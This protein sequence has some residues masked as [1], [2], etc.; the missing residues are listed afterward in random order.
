VTRTRRLGALLIA[1]PLAAGFT[2]FANPTA[3]HAVSGRLPSGNITAP[4]DGAV[5]TSG[6]QVTA[7]ATFR[8]MLLGVRLR[9]KTPDG[10][11]QLL[12]SGSMKGE[13]SGTFNIRRNGRY[14]VR[15]VGTT[16][17][18]YDTSTIVVKV[19]PATPSGLSAKVSGGTL[20]VTWNLGLEDD[21]TGYTVQAGGVGSKSGSPQSL[22]SGTICS[23]KFSLGSVQADS[24]RVSV[25]ARRPDGLGGSVSSGAAS[26]S[27]Q[28]PGGGG[29]GDDGG[30][31]G[32]N[33]GNG[34]NGGGGSPLPLPEFN[35]EGG[36]NGGGGGT[37][38]TPFNDE[39][40]ITLPSV[41]PDGATPGF[42]YPA[43]LVAG[44][45]ADGPDSAISGLQWGKSVATALILLLVAAHLGT[46]TRRMRVAQAG[47][48]SRGMAARAARSGS[49]RARVER[50][51]K[52]IAR[53]QS[54]AKSPSGL[55]R[56]LGGGTAAKQTPGAKTRPAPAAPK[57]R[58]PARGATP[59]VKPGA[60]VRGTAPAAK[61][62]A[63]ARGGMPS[64]RPA[65]SAHGAAPPTRPQ[66]IVRDGAPAAK[67]GA[68]MRPGAP[69]MKPGSAPRVGAPAAGPAAGGAQ[70][71]TGKADR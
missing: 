52:H 41:Q 51:Q 32:D 55:R 21:L 57:T 9:V 56:L 44:Q 10:G 29:D 22:C 54:S 28:I 65:P 63:P 47:L 12:A 50:T 16:T 59:A 58:R 67:P 19:P 36:G 69:V 6:T 8:D 27:V 66:P 40:P 68:E 70:A 53:A 64:G 37:P 48:S 11:D 33:G 17:T 2:I 49:G 3:V 38:L 35:G 25:S 15:L 5:I 42:T 60:S 7:R 14:T 18:V 39:S 20:S 45:N 34:G 31:G 24:V 4:A 1:T 23:A 46:W 71:P 62:G 43:P 26:T 30:R 61:P 13:I